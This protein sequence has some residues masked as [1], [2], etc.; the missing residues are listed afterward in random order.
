M[1]ALL[2]AHLEHSSIQRQ[3]PVKTVF[4]PAKH[5]SVLKALAQAASL[6]TSIIQLA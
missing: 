4:L 3:L 1:N 2:A 6:A 5:V